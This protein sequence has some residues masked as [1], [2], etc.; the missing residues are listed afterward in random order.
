[1][2]KTP[3]KEYTARSRAARQDAGGKAVYVMLTPQEAAAL[4]Q[5]Q[6]KLGLNIRDAIGIAL[7]ELAQARR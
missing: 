3:R 4:S 1:M 5:L 6:A 2:L 7:L